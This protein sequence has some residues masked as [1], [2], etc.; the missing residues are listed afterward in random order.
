MW[1]SRVRPRI[2]TRHVLRE[3]GGEIEEGGHAD[4]VEARQRHGP[5]VHMGD[6][7]LAIHG[8]GNLLSLALADDA[9]PLARHDPDR[10][11]LHHIAAHDQERVA[12]V[13]TSEPEVVPTRLLAELRA[14]NPA[15]IAG[16][17]RVR[18]GLVLEAHVAGESPG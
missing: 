15:E 1:V 16:F 7:D 6:D 9:V 3:D 10:G 2:G 14:D 17:F 4:P 13:L 18:H 8:E 12:V 11:P 5:I